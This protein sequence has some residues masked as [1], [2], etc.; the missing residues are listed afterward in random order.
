MGVMAHSTVVCCLLG[1]V[2]SV[3]TSF[4][5]DSCLYAFCFD[6]VI[7]E[8]SDIQ[9]RPLCHITNTFLHSFS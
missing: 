7:C 3:T 5:L 9:T 6:E 4:C 2:T 8:R 1:T